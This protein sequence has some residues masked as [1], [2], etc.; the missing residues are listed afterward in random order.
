METSRDIILNRIRVAIDKRPERKLEK[1]DFSSPVQ[2]PIDKDLLEKFKEEF[3]ENLGQTYLCPDS[4]DVARQL[5]S[6][7]ADYHV[8]KFHCIDSEIQTFLSKENIS[9]SFEKKDFNDMEAGCTGCEY[10]IARSGSIMVSSSQASGRAMNVFPPCHIVLARKSQL[11][12]EIADALD[13]IQKKYGDNIPS[14][15]STITGP[16]RTADIEKTLVMGAHGPKQLV[17]F[18]DLSK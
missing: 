15:I 12:A 6:Y 18:I 10:L 7:L 5:K 13:A 2:H 16:S 9:F 17:V 8:K 11:V 3:D 1:P 4:Q 14:M